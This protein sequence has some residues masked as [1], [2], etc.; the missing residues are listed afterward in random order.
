VLDFLGIRGALGAT[1]PQLV[2]LVLRE[3]APVILAGLAIGLAFALAT[4]RL[5][6]SILFE[7]HATTP[8]VLAAATAAFI[9]AAILAAAL[10]ARRAARIDPAAALRT[11]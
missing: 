10:P 3:T 5:F 4:V 7:V 11:E 1:R 8:A 2:S 9:G 6:D